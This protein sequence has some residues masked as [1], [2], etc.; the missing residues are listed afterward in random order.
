M[1]HC[2]HG[3]VGSHRDWDLFKKD[4]NDDL[5]AHDLWNLS[6]TGSASLAAAGHEIARLAHES[7]VL[8]GYSMGGRIALHALLAAPKKWKAAIIISAHSGLLEGHDERLKHDANWAILANQDWEAFLQKWNTQSI[9]PSTTKG[10]VQATSHDQ[11]AVVKSFLHWSLGAQENLLPQLSDLSIPIL[12][13]TGEEDQKFT[14]LGRAA[15]SKIPNAHHGVIS[16]CGHRVPWE[17][18]REFA[19]MVN[20]FLS[21]L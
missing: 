19:R 17:K 4:L 15:S 13:V 6:D 21:D 18:P 7:D 3:A 2:L 5:A 8:M 16:N 20:D 12:W 1:I 11:E 9:L 10:M 14:Q